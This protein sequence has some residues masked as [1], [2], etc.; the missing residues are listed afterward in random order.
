MNGLGMN[1]GNLSRLSNAVT[2]SISAENP[3]GEKGKGGMAM[4]EPGSPSR[5][6]GQGWKCRPC[7]VIKPGETVTIADIVGSGA[8]Q[9]MWTAAYIGRDLILRIYWDD[10]EQPSVEVPFSDFFAVPFM[11]QPEPPN[12]PHK[13][14][15]M[16]INSLPVCVNPNRG[17]N[18]FWEMP[19]RKHCIMTVENIHPVNNLVCYYQINYTLCDVPDDCA[20]FHAQFRRVNPLPYGETYKILDGVKGKGHYVGTSMGWGIN[21]NVW[22]GEGEIKF[23]LDGDDK[24]PTICGTGT[25][26]YFL[27]A[28]NWDCDGNY[29]EYS[30]PYAGMH[31]VRPDG[32]YS[33]QHRHYMYRWHIVDPVRFENDIKVDIQ[34][35]GWRDCGRFLPGMH[36]ICSVAYW[37]QTLPTAPFPELPCRDLLELI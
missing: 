22:W 3:T 13:G 30:T 12:P 23:Y 11:Q 29:T 9:S 25:E 8:L 17:A 19:F 24:F 27:G 7:I 36:D 32:L 14:P 1:I 33:A 16:T 15:L 10:Q 18:C 26:D 6:L 34:A 4:P 37:Y 31:V 21:N 2:R 20:Y 5:E 35:L 28:Y